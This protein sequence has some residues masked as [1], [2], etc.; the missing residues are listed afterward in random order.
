[1]EIIQS[2][3]GLF[4]L[5]SGRSV[6][7]ISGIWK[8]FFPFLKYKRT[9]NSEDTCH[10][11]EEYLEIKSNRISERLKYEIAI[12]TGNDVDDDNAYE[13]WYL[14]GIFEKMAWTQ[15]CMSF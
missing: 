8:I 12:L 9:S 1:M 13:L 3:W 7:Y 10:T 6:I 5:A 11:Y 14:R 4:V 15:C 2:I